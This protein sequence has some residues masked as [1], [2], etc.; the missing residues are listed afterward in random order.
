MPKMDGI[1]MNPLIGLEVNGKYKITRKIGKDGN[2]EVCAI[3]ILTGD[4]FFSREKEYVI[5]V[6]KVNS[7]DVNEI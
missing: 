2:G 5:K 7:H 4:E 6:L 1:S 3:D